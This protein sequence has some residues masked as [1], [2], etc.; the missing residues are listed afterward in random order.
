[1]PTSPM[2]IN[3]P[4]NSCLSHQH[5][6]ETVF[7]R[8]SPVEYSPHWGPPAVCSGAGALMVL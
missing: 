1:M 3:N 2:S 4:I 7:E 8:P 6:L 5:L